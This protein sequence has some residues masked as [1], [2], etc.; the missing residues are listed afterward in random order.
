MTAFC[1]GFIAASALIAVVV[2]GGSW[3]ALELMDGR[4]EVPF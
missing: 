4:A 3:I 1:C 2:V